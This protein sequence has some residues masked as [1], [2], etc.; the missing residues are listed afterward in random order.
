MSKYTEKNNRMTH[1]QIKRACDAVGKIEQ[2]VVEEYF[3][4]KCGCMVKVLDGV[5]DVP[6]RTVPTG[7]EV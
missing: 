3:D 5:R 1:K 2:K 4:L 7:Y 6:F